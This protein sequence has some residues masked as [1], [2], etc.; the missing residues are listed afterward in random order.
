VQV[1]ATITIKG[2]LNLGALS[3]LHNPYDGHQAHLALETD[4]PLLSWSKSQLLSE[5]LVRIVGN[6]SMDGPSLNNR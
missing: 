5:F 6:I 2:N 4:I 1:G 3:F